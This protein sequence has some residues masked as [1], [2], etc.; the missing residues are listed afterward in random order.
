MNASQFLA[1]LEQTED[2]YVQ[3]AGLAGGHFKSKRAGRTRRVL[4]RA[5]MA[6]AILFALSA[7]VFGVGELIGIWNDRWLQTPAADPTQVVR[8]AIS[9]QTEKEYTISVRVDELRVDE[10]EKALV[11]AGD[12]NCELARRNGFGSSAEALRQL[13]PEQLVVVYVRYTVEYDHTKT[14]YPDGTLDQYFYLKRNEEGNWEIA[15]STDTQD[16]APG[17]GHAASGGGAE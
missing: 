8:E 9:R 5:L 11:L 16:A 10:S 17:S 15:E 13:D 2:V 6:A 14:F 7:T 12:L 1:A 3:Q 4:F